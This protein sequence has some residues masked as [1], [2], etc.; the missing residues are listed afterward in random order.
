MYQSLAKAKVLERETKEKLYKSIMEQIKTIRNPGEVRILIEKAMTI[1]QNGF[2]Q[3]KDLA[4]MTEAELI[5]AFDDAYGRALA[6]VAQEIEM[7]QKFQTDDEYQKMYENIKKAVV[8]KQKVVEDLAQNVMQFPKHEDLVSM[9]GAQVI[10]AIEDARVYALARLAQEVEMLQKYQTDDEYQKNQ[11]TQKAEDLRYNAVDKIVET[12]N[13]KIKQITPP[14]EE[15]SKMNE[16]QLAALFDKAHDATIT[17]VTKEIEEFAKTATPEDIL[18]NE[19]Q[20]REFMATAQIRI[21]AA[22]AKALVSLNNADI[23]EKEATKV[24]ERFEAWLPEMDSL[25]TMDLEQF[26]CAIK[27]AEDK[28]MALLAADVEELLKP[29]IPD[30]EDKV[31][32]ADITTA[33]KNVV[34]ELNAAIAPALKDVA[35]KEAAKKLIDSIE[36]MF[37]EQLG[38]SSEYLGLSKA[39]LESATKD[40]K[41]ATLVLLSVQVNELKKTHVTE[42]MITDAKSS[43]INM[44]TNAVQ[45]AFKNHA[46]KI[47]EEVKKI[48]AAF[49][50]QLLAMDD[51][52]KMAK[53]GVVTAFKSAEETAPAVLFADIDELSKEI[54]SK[55]DPDMVKNALAESV[56]KI[57]RAVEEAYKPLAPAQVAEEMRKLKSTFENSLPEMEKF[58][59]MSAA[60]VKSIILQAEMA[61]LALLDAD[62]EDLSKPVIHLDSSKITEAKSAAIAKLTKAVTE[63]F[64]YIKNPDKVREQLDGVLSAFN[65]KTPSPTVSVMSEADMKAAVAE[66]EQT[67]FVYLAAQVEK[68]KPIAGEKVKPEEITKAMSHVYSRIAEAVT[69]ALEPLNNPSLVEEEIKGIKSSFEKH[70]N[71]VDLLE[72]TASEM[73]DAI[74]YAEDFA[75]A[76][77]TDNVEEIMKEDQLSA[78]DESMI[79]AAKQNAVNEIKS[80]IAQILKDLNDR[81]SATDL[82][83]AV[84]S[85]FENELEDYENLLKLSQ[86]DLA[87][88]IQDAKKAALSSLRSDAQHLIK[89]QLPKSTPITAAPTIAASPSPIPAKD[90]KDSKD[91]KGDKGT[92]APLEDSHPINANPEVGKD[93]KTTSEAGRPT[94]NP[95]EGTPN[96]KNGD[97]ADVDPN[98]DEKDSEAE[99]NKKAAVLKQKEKDG[100]E[101]DGSGGKG[102]KADKPEVP[103]KHGKPEE[104]EEHEEHGESTSHDSSSSSS[105]SHDSSSSSSSSHDSSS[106]SSSSHDDG[107]TKPR[108]TKDNDSLRP[109]KKEEEDSKKEEEDS[110]KHGCGASSTTTTTDASES[111]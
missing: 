66:A 99:K 46:D 26:T 34:D 25:L 87:T 57:A 42:V 100:A 73:K 52:L 97:N 41:K 18:L 64:A 48:T 76:D 24:K 44:L 43:T 67:A 19:S 38:N 110:K 93:T 60:D 92:D 111:D 40:A 106:S 89:T 49:N 33:A 55:V 109:A 104:H 17:F 16:A 62:E 80:T 82:L 84:Q 6:R 63:A 8:L 20:I 78:V 83:N 36:A 30:P 103:E 85:R 81:E 108:K 91:G 95:S 7:M 59:L 65:N 74:Q 47:E 21:D 2:P 11:A 79:V 107:N 75:M 86:K 22:I 98:A 3:V 37:A 1:L 50:A 105:S 71:K 53:G 10:A 15:M 35:D 31:V 58:L 96:G 77:S 61:V 88:A 32:L 28:A 4:A 90:G 70:L 45:N 29:V 94:E 12:I 72:M 101:K 102:G 14:M 13:E 39:V 69:K 9:T 54:P 5:A 23:V 56:D 27:N 51:L 68:L